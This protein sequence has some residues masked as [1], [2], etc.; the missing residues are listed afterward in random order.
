MI[1]SDAENF[2]RHRGYGIPTLVFFWIENDSDCL[3]IQQNI[4]SLT[5]KFTEANN[6]RANWQ[7]YIKF[8]L[9]RQ[10]LKFIQYST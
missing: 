5:C 3:K 6:I 8:T 9:F 7:D 1:V 10:I 4:Q 2:Q